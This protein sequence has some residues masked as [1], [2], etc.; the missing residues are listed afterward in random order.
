M[1]TIFLS[2]LFLSTTL[3]GFS[4]LTV[5]LP[6]IGTTPG[7]VIT[8]PVTL[9]GASSSGTPIS[10]ADIRFT[11]NPAVLT[12]SGI[13]NFNASMPSSQWFFS[14][15]NTTGLVSANWLEPSL[16]TLSIPDN[17]TLYEIQFTYL[18]GNSALNFSFTEFTDASYNVIP[19]TKVNGSVGPDSKTL[20]LTAFIEGLFDGTSSMYKSQDE[21][22]DHFAANIAEHV[23]IEL[24]DASSYSN[25]AYTASNVELSVSGQVS[26]PIPS[27]YNG[28]YYITIKGRNHVETT[29][30][31][32]V[33]F[34]GATISYDFSAASSAFGD[35][36]ILIN[37]V[38]CLYSGDVN[39]DGI[40]ESSDMIAIDNLV[41]SFGAG[42]IPEDVNGD[43]LIDSSDMIMV[44][45][46]ATVFIGSVLP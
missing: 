28:S 45:N 15:S 22:G 25:I 24:H 40:I 46:N 43:G 7:S 4:Q 38:Y 19:A 14:G 44:D 1:K 33:S 3:L 30:S 9:S 16:L 8:V 26:I 5:S 17:S 37:G 29:S 31:S 36:E 27:T 11:F 10:A 34:A 35:N 20:N 23:T 13:V 41:S 42:Y 18:G 21:S 6:T 32:P 12:Y 2:L 39:Q